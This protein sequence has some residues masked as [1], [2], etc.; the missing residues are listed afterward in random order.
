MTIKLNSKR[1][2]YLIKEIKE[3]LLWP[4]LLCFRTHFIR[5]NPHFLQRL[6]MQA[7][8]MLNS[9][10]LD[11]SFLKINPIQDFFR[12]FHSV[13]A[14]TGWHH[15]KHITAAPLLKHSKNHNIESKVELKP[16]SL[17]DASDARDTS[18]FT[19]L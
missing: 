14:A 16:C 15:T 11:R 12:V 6:C 9:D 17:K 3:M 13:K 4:F 8:H 10:N 1:R 19:Q 18:I 5:T 7:L 2:L